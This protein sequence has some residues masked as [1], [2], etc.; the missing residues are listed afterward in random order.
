MRGQGE[1]LA[2]LRPVALDVDH[3]SFG[4]EARA[5]PFAPVAGFRR[6]RHALVVL[7]RPDPICHAP[8]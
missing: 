4:P 3:G 5:R 8:E 6:E 2:E 7:R 1:P